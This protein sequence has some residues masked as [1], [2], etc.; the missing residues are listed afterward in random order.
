MLEMTLDTATTRIEGGEV[1]VGVKISPVDTVIDGMENLMLVGVVVA[2]S[3]A[4][5]RLGSPDTGYAPV[6]VDVIGGPWGVP[7]NL[8]YATELDTL[9]STPLGNWP[10][11][12]IGV[13]VFVQDTST[14][15]VLQ[16]VTK[17]KLP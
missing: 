11:D 5:T 8:R 7:V 10:L 4:H 12:R 13:A 1:R 14:K 6:A 2:D 3:V 17:R 9:I 16:T 15:E